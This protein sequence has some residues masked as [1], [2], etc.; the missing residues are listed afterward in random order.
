MFLHT[1]LNG[2]AVHRA[3]PLLV[4]LPPRAEF[5]RSIDKRFWTTRVDKT[6][7]KAHVGTYP[8]GDRDDNATTEGRKQI[9]EQIPQGSSSV[10]VV[11]VLIEPLLPP[12]R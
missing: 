8:R 7:R 2:A 4:E 3:E 9:V 1:L 10:V 5:D 6:N 12:R 11:V